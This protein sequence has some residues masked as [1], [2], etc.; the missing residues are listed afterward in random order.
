MIESDDLR[1]HKDFEGLLARSRIIELAPGEQLVRQGEASE[2]A[3]FLT[4]GSMSVY[5][6]TSYGE[7]PLATFDAPRL[8]GEIGAL[9]NLPRTA[10]IRAAT[11]AKLRVI[12]RAQ[13][14]DFGYQFPDL[15]LAAIQQLGQQIATVNEA[16]GLYANALAALGER[17]FDEG[18]L[19]DLDNPSPA[20]AAFA[21]AFRRFADE[22]TR[23]RRYQEEMASA[24]MI[25]KSFLP[26]EENINSRRR[27]VQIAA[28]IRPTREVGGDFYDFFVIDD[29]RLAILIGD[30]CGKGAPASLFAARVVTLLRILGRDRR[31]AGEVISRANAQLC[32]ENDASMFATAFFGVLDLNSGELTY[33]N[34]GHVAPFHLTSS[35]EVKRLGRTGLP[36][37]I[38]ADLI[39]SIA[40]T[41]I[42]AGEK[43]LMI[44]DGVTEAI[45][46]ELNEFGEGRLLDLL[47]TQNSLSPTAVLE[48]IFRAV[49][50]FAD[51]AD[52]ADDIGCLIVER[53]AT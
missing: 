28:R 27:D 34:C 48:E 24:A 32:E 11:H 7:A 13:I 17:G 3:Y 45:D 50:A 42:A 38:D 31:E 8:M 37:A 10:S 36:L 41:H 15:L 53:R 51:K 12:E 4:D 5:V 35:G 29:S 23:K 52:Q 20:L 14:V 46:L 9:A 26:K 33:C 19:S 43:L 22:I 44:T 2:A 1:L 30:V 49:D 40:T 6:V 21:A 47:F 39:T 16:L 18:I 25:Q